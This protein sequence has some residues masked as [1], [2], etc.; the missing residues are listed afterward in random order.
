MS[1]GILFAGMF[2]K[3]GHLEETRYLIR[4]AEILGTKRRWFEFN[5]SLRRRLVNI[6]LRR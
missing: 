6:S 5:R 4:W 2:K 1:D 3:Q